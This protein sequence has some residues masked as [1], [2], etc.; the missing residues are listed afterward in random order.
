MLIKVDITK[1]FNMVEWD[2]VLATLHLMKF[3]AI[4][5]KWIR[6]CLSSTNFAILINRH[7]SSWFLSCRGLR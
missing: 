3:L 4:W 1:D 2:V 7:V 6:A 5:I